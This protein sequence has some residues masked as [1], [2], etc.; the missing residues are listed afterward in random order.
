[1]TKTRL[2]VQVNTETLNKVKDRIKETGLVTFN[3]QDLVQMFLNKV[4]DEGVDFDI[5][6]KIQ[7]LP[8]Y[9]V[10]PKTERAIGRAL[11]NVKKGR[12]KTL[13]SDEDIDAHLNRLIKE[14][15]EESDI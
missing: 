13:N 14:G 1:M 5:K 4:A 3:V 11:E 12:F 9:K 6:F 2:Q 8:S 7:S 15:H 10:S